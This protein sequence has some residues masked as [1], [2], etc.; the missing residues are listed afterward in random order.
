MGQEP[1]WSPDGSEIVVADEAI[2]KPSLRTTVSR[3]WKVR[4]S[5][6][7]ATL[8]ETGDA[9]QPSWSPGG[10]RIAYWSFSSET[11]RRSIWTIRSDGREPVEVIGDGKVNW[12]PVWSPDGRY[13]YFLSDRG[14]SQN[15]WRVRIDEESGRVQGQPEPV[16]APSKSVSGLSLSGDG[17][18]ILY[19]TDDSQANVDMVEL[20]PEAGV[21]LG[22]LK[23]V[24]GGSWSI[25]TADI[26][27]DGGRIAFYTQA[28]EEEIFVVPIS[29]GEPRQL[30]RD[31]YKDRV[32]RWSPDGRSILF[33]SNRSGKYEAW[34]IGADGGGLEQLTRLDQ[35]VYNPVWSPDGRRLAINL[36]AELGALIDLRLPLES[37]RPQ[38]LAERGEE[39]GPFAPDSWSPDG[40]WLAG[41]RSADGFDLYSFA[42]RRFEKMS[43]H[44][45]YVTWLHDSRR[46]LYLDQGSLWLFDLE[47]KSARE[48]LA[49]PP[50]SAFRRVAVS[51]DDR[52]LCLVSSAV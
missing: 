2:V 40:R 10:K 25:L 46:L 7:E 43:D 16:G 30:T 19:A 50:E 38:P 1:A 27:P 26:S 20:D 41:Y 48:L 29:G 39:P 17:H 36:G 13:L 28:P 33:Y 52:A 44:G 11:G 37:R 9:V 5:D 45:N 6:G 18:R 3:L 35:P 8:L 32:P 15:I 21:V 49:P 12:H 42:A 47:T 24:T 23:P 34:K 22:G 31:T 51:R 4:V 14:G